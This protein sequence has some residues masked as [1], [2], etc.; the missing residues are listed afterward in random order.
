[1][2]VWNL[3]ANAQS[4]IHETPLDY[5]IFAR[6]LFHCGKFGPSTMTSTTLPNA[7]FIVVI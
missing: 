2:R 7:L 6:G 1:M 4:A 3:K 5:Y